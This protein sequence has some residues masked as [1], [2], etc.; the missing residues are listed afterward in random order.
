MVFRTHSFV[1]AWLSLLSF[2]TKTTSIVGFMRCSLARSYHNTISVIGFVK[3]AR[4]LHQEM[5]CGIVIPPHRYVLQGDGMNWTHGPCRVVSRLDDTNYEVETDSEGS[6]RVRVRH[7]LKPYEDDV[8]TRTS[9]PLHLVVPRRVSK[10]SS[11]PDLDADDGM[12]ENILDVRWN[13]ALQRHWLGWSEKDNAYKPLGSFLTETLFR[14]LV[15]KPDL[16]I[17]WASG[18]RHRK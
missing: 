9:V 13:P 10:Q 3:S 7:Q 5:H 2:N 11:L 8:L 12:P 1:S 14:Y 17:N 6:I 18:W 16:R 4:L 15:G